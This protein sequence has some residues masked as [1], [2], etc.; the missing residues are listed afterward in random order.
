MCCPEILKYAT[1]EE[2]NYFTC[3]TNKIIVPRQFSDVLDLVS[4]Y[5]VF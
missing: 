1:E 3:L 4:N 5:T 2:V